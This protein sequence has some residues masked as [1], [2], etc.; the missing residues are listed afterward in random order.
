M[1]KN[2]DRIEE[3]QEKRHEFILNESVFADD[4]PSW[5]EVAEAEQKAELKWNETAEGKELRELLAIKDIPVR[6]KVWVGRRQKELE[7][8]QKEGET[9]PTFAALHL[10]ELFEEYFSKFDRDLID[11]LKILFPKES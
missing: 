10:A 3:L 4:N 6:A 1:T 7:Y 5:G 11:D 8:V 9:H 2:Q